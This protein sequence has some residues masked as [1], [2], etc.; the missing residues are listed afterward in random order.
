MSLPSFAIL[1]AAFRPGAS[2]P[3]GITIGVPPPPRWEEKSDEMNQEDEDW[4]L[5]LEQDGV[6]A[7]EMG[8]PVKQVHSTGKG[9]WFVP[10]TPT[11]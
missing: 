8:T 6:R 7:K 3:L 5:E 11:I 1:G 9:G 2:P 10:D 4:L